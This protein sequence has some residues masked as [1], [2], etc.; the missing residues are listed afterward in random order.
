MHKVLNS[1]INSHVTSYEDLPT[2]VKYFQEANIV[3]MLRIPDNKPAIDNLTSVV[4]S[5]KILST[6]IM[7]SP[8][9]LSYEGQYLSGHKLVVQL[10]LDEKIKYVSRRTTESVQATH[11]CQS[12]K[13]I[14]IV[15]PEKI[16]NLPVADLIRTRDFSVIPYIEHIYTSI[17][18]SRNIYKCVS[19]LVDVK[20]FN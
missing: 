15:V 6:K 7:E 18:D 1:Q 19:I 13:S 4:V 16:N 11:F 2:N 8:V 5:P 10:S 12:V 14:F 3:E 17:K 9:A 20:F